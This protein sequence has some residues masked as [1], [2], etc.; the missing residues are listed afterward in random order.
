MEEEKMS[1]PNSLECCESIYITELRAYTPWV[2]SMDA[3]VFTAGHD[4]SESISCRDG[5]AGQI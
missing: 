5:D 4:R 3:F 1:D 2:S